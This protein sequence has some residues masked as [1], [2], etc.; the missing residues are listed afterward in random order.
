[1]LSG[2]I[3]K[4][5]RSCVLRQPMPPS[6]PES[7]GQARTP[8]V[9]YYVCLLERQR[10]FIKSVLPANDFAKNG[11]DRINCKILKHRSIPQPQVHCLIFVREP[12]LQWNVQTH[13]LTSPSTEQAGRCPTWGFHFV[14]L[15]TLVRTHLG[16]RYPVK[17]QSP[18]PRSQA[19]WLLGR[20]MSPGYQ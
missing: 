1:M 20:G 4:E 11:A 3:A 17:R 15:G 6:Q 2:F 14:Q 19:A 12:G 10:P 13:N 5:S 7:G 16:N 8:P 9:R 18:E